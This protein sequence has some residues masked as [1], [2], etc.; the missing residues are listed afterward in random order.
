LV[1]QLATAM[2]VSGAVADPFAAKERGAAVPAGDN[3]RNPLVPLGL[4]QRISRT[5][6]ELAERQ[7]LVLGVDD[8]HLADEHSLQ[9]LRYLIRR[10]DSSAVMIVMSES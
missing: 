8:L 5:V 7:P 9:C 1:E 3:G 6:C 2:R 4:L 10:I